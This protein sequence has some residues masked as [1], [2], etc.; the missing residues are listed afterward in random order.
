MLVDAGTQYASIQNGTY[1][2][3][4]SSSF[5]T[6]SQDPVPGKPA[7]DSDECKIPCPGDS[8]KFCGG[9]YRNIVYKFY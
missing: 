4:D 7:N 1:C 2:Y 8:T 6:P 3:C 5:D 9:I